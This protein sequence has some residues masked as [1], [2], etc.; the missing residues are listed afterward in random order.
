VNIS[1]QDYALLQR[2][3]AAPQMARL[4]P[5]G[6]IF[7]APGRLVNPLN[8]LKGAHWTKETVYRAAWHEKVAAGLVEASYHRLQGSINPRAPKVVTMRAH[9]AKLFD[10]LTEGL[11]AACKPIP[12]ALKTFRIIHADD[13]TCGHK[14]VYEQIVDPHWLGV[15]VEVRPA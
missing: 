9:V 11:Q 10:S 14:F 3:K 8:R 5:G 7:C 4:L 6:V 1:S 13:D 2:R 12:D 15:E